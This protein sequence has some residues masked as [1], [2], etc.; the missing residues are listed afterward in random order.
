MIRFVF[1]V[2]TF[3]A[4]QQN[5]TYFSRQI[6]SLNGLGP[7]DTTYR[8]YKARA[9]LIKKHEKSGKTEH[10]LL[11]DAPKDEAKFFG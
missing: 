8:S 4:D 10:F 9:R 2:S 11:A 7:H 6:L 1:Y 5:I 3:P